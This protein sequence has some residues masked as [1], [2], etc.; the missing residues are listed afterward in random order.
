MFTLIVWWQVVVKVAIELQHR[1]RGW[2]WEVLEVEVGCSDHGLTSTT[3]RH[4]HPWCSVRHLV[5][6]LL[7]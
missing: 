5:L 4:Y 3:Q 6:T 7:C 2:Q 1:Q